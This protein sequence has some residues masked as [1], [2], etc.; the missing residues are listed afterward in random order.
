[1]RVFDQRFASYILLRIYSRPGISKK[2]AVDENGGSIS[3]KYDTLRSLIDAG[4]VE[5]Q[6]ENS[7]FETKTV[8]LTDLGR[9]V[10]ERLWEIHEMMP[11]FECDSRE[12]K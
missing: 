5:V 2:E 4:L 7:M 3:A 6:G 10:A 1:M 11:H 12:Y 9:N 8:T